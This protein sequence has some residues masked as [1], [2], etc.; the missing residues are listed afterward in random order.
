MF[1]IQTFS[2]LKIINFLS[3]KKR[4]E[5]TFFSQSQLSILTKRTIDYKKFAKLANQK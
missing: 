5:T 2:A 3:S 4:I 1:N